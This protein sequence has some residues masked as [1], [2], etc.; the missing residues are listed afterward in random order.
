MKILLSAYAC[1]PGRGSEQAVGWRWAHELA[2]AGH[3]IVAL[4]RANN[5]SVITAAGA[6]PS[7]RFV[8]YD[9]PWIFKKLKR[10]PKFAKFYYVLWQIGAYSTVR[11]LLRQE[12]FDLIHHLTFSDFRTYSPLVH[13]N[14]PF[15]IG[16]LG[17]AE[18]APP[19]L[20]RSLPIQARVTE[21]LRTLAILA[22]QLN[23]LTRAMYARASLIICK[24]PET[25]AAIPKAK[26]GNL[27]LSREIGSPDRATRS[28]LL[29]RAAA[30][31]FKLMYAGRLVYWKG[32]HLALKAYAIARQKDKTLQF[33][34]VGEGRDRDRLIALA[35]EL[36]LDESVCWKFH[37]PQQQLF[38]IQQEAHAFIFPSL[39][40][41]GGSVVLEAF[42]HGLPVLCLRTGGPG[43][44][45]DESCGYRVPVQ[46]RREGEIVQE[47]AAQI[48]KWS[49]C[50]KIWLALAT[51]AL[52]KAA[53]T[54]WQATVEGTYS[55]IESI[56]S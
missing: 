20:L 13:L 43:L 35:G 19:L 4:T 7:L 34:I 15:V 12:S 3:E 33:T 26:P 10:G 27:R 44:N 41:S 47:L 30:Q 37:L 39:H 1:E 22:A 21:H 51:R 28:S 36:E 29:S 18:C 50:R 46:D 25:L 23:P 9:L 32:L 54:S 38:E 49:S 16:P 8:Y 11:R 17:G 45:V 53:E 14:V 24:T 40:D 52:E 5:K 6:N 56:I 2:A 48:L 31:E 55:H 42:A